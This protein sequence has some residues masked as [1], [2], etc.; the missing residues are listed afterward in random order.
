MKIKLFLSSLV[1]SPH[2]FHFW[3]RPNRQIIMWKSLRSRSCHKHTHTHARSHPLPFDDTLVCAT[4]WKSQSWNYLKYAGNTQSALVLN[5]KLLENSRRGYTLT[6]STINS[7]RWSIFMDAVRGNFSFFALVL[8]LVDCDNIEFTIMLDWTKAKENRSNDEMF[9]RHLTFV[10]L[11]HPPSLSVLSVP[12]IG[13][14]SNGK[15]FINKIKIP[16]K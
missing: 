4:K 3:V 11:S 5:W 10:R 14:P 16:R 12:F 1:C 8:I 2:Q 13:C 7:Y 15:R 6:L 9:V